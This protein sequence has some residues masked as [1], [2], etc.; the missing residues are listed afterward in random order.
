MTEIHFNPAIKINQSKIYQFFLLLFTFSL[1]L[2]I[3]LVRA[4]FYFKI[5]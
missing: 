3:I 2:E 4:S 1:L 5:L